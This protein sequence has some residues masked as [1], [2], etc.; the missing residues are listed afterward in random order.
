MKGPMTTQSLRGMANHGPM[1]WRGDRNG[2]LDS[3]AAPLDEVAAFKK[4][5]VAFE[6]L[7]GRSGPI[8]DSDMQAFTDFVLQVT[9]PPNPI[10]SLDNS[11]TPEQQKGYDLFTGPRKFDGA[12]NCNGCHV[13]DPNARPGSAIPGFF[14]SSGLSSFDFL[15]QTFKVPHLRNLYQKVGMFG[16]PSASIFNPVTSP[17]GVFLPGNLDGP[18]GDQIRGFGFVH[19][20]SID[21]PFRFH[22]TVFFTAIPGFNPGGF[23]QGPEGAAEIAQMEAFL[24]VFDTN[25]APIVGQ[26]ATLA[27][28]NAATV[29][30]RVTL[31][32]ARADV[33]ECD[34]I[35]KTELFHHE[36][37]FLYVGNGQFLGDRAGWPQIS[38]AMLRSLATIPD[39]EV[40][41]TCVP[42]G[43]GARLGIDRD[44]DGFL[45]GDEVDAC[46]DPADPDSTP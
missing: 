35:A 39:H 7:L 46:S 21:T 34:L 13:I 40:T 6:G 42:R 20:G 9:Y 36:T 32:Q 1:H 24:F 4:F 11:L 43:S 12:D 30:P 14:G 28:G 18:T 19:D 2:G 29:G 23:P 37:G 15:P 3:P 5:N 38:G 10:R 27:S 8:S 41:F 31:L 22:N 26:Q 45:D 17:G 25:L 16:V 33:G 44:D